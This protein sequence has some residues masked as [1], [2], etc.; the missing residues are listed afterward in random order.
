MEALVGSSSG[1]A[2]GEERLEDW[3]RESGEECWNA[4]SS[5]S[6]IESDIYPK[7]LLAV[8]A[9]LSSA[10]ILLHRLDRE[11]VVVAGAA[12]GWPCCGS[13]L[14]GATSPAPAAAQLPT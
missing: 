11:R 7:T 14:S 9:T 13:W 5:P 4:N 1:G 2:G 8:A 12:V 6:C 3:R 10:A